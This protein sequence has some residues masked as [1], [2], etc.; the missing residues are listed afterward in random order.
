MK[1]F[2]QKGEK[3]YLLLHFIQ[4]WKLEIALFNFDFNFLIIY[5]IFHLIG[6]LIINI[7]SFNFHE[8]ASIFRN[9]DLDK[10]EFSYRKILR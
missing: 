9:I 1:S 10:E 2:C 5:F 4:D 7:F 8:N 3:I 6:V